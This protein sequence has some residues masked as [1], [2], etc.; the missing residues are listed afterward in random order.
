MTRLATLVVLVIIE[1]TGFPAGQPQPASGT[2]LILGR[3]VDAATGTP[4]SG[5]VVTAVGS[6]DSATIPPSGQPQSMLTD[7]QGRF[8][9]RNLPKGA[10]ALTATIGGRGFS[11]SAERRWNDCKRNSRPRAGPFGRE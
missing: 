5:V 7:A 11:P 3:V 8:V 6:A 1:A 2:A 4:V 9:F 10:Y